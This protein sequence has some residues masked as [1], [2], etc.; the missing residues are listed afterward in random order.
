MAF[1][2]LYQF[3][4]TFIL[5]YRK[6]M[7]HVKDTKSNLEEFESTFEKKY[8][9]HQAAE[10]IQKYLLKS[11]DHKLILIDEIDNLSQS[12]STRTFIQFLT[13]VLK[14]DT[15]TTIIGIANSVD[16]I[17]KV[18]EGGKKEKS[19]VQQKLVFAPYNE[20]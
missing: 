15:K 16:L 11:A 5:D 18:H 17:S 4:K 9:L 12:E 3:C 13:N 1:K 7:F 19:L 14:H 10:K 8:D 6:E 20:Q 2:N